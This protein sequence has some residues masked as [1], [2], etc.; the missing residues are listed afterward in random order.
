MV[1]KII[2]PLSKKRADWFLKHLKKEHPKLSRRAR[3]R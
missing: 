3:I 2:I 1:K